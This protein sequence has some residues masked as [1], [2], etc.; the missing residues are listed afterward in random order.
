MTEGDPASNERSSPLG[1][2]LAWSVHVFTASG[3][4]LALLALVAIEHEQW[5]LALSWLFLAL[6]VDGVDGSLARW[7]K[8]K[9]RAPQIDGDTLDLVV[10]YLTYV[11]VPTIF[12][13]RAGLVPPQLAWGLAGAIQLSS[14]YLFARTDMKTDDGYFRGFPALWNLVAFY[15]FVLQPGPATGAAVVLAL[16]ALTFAPVHFVHPFRVRD[17]GIWLPLLATMWAI[18]TCGLLFARG[19]P[20]LHGLLAGLSVSSAFLLLGLGLC[21]TLRGAL[22]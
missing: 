17:Y 15:L 16:S 10:D 8:V 12:I 4:L 7:A 21:R 11:F 14:L 20:V 19:E 6:V 18:A 2:V 9:A 3:A 1:I 22:P 5:G 13:V